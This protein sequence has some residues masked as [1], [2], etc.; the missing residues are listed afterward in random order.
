MKNQ[1]EQ[2]KKYYEVIIHRGVHIIVATPGRLSDMLVKGKFN[3]SLCKYLTLDEADRLLDLG[4]ED[5]I[6]NILEHFKVCLRHK[7][8]VPKTDSALFSHNA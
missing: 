1:V 8:K 2:T 7:S 3:L 4:F 6:R 5:E